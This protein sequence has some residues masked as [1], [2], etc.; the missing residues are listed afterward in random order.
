[1]IEL[2]ELI[3]LIGLIGLIELF[4]VDITSLFLPQVTP[5][6]KRSLSAANNVWEAIL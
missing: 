3:E 6:A 1:L 2:I 5:K 4:L